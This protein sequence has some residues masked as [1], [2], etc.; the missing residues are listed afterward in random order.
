MSKTFRFGLVA[1]PLIISLFSATMMA[2]GTPPAA[3]AQEPPA[4]QPASP[5]PGLPQPPQGAGIPSTMT[6]APPTPVPPKEPYILEDGGFYIQPY[7]WLVS[8]APRLRGGHAATNIADL[9]FNG[10]PKRAEGVEVGIPAGRSNTIRVTLF[11]IQG[12]SGCTL[13]Q[14]AIVYGEQ[15][16]AGYFL[17]ATYKVESIK[18]SWDYLSYTW[19]KDKT[20]IHIKT[21][22][23]AQ[24]IKS[25]FNTAP[26]FV[27]GTADATGAGNL[28]TG[29]E[30]VILPTFGLAVGSAFGKYFRW[31]VRASGLAGPPLSAHGS[32]H[33]SII[34]DVEASVA[35]RVSKVDV[36]V[37]ERYLYYKT[38]PGAAM[39]ANETLQG[40]YG[41]L[42][43]VWRGVQ[44]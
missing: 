41:G 37:G 19:R 6:V 28:A 3:P 23:E 5:Q 27:P 16:Y 26:P 13:P 36:I 4:Q 44:K 7:Y 17:N 38:S 9:R 21:L 11:R 40:V 10:R 25:T 29:S 24:Y 1:T 43:F 12:N 42:R 39:Y 31:D 18:A 34:A 35:A 33:S 15:Y 20:N 22:F 8:G 2:Q 32:V 30:S 14:D